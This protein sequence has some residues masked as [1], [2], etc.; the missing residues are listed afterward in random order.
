MQPNERQ[1]RKYN[2]PF[3]VRKYL[4]S[5]FVIFTFAAYALH[6]H[7]DSSE[8]VA[9]MITPT[10][11]VSIATEVS[12]ATDIP[13]PSATP[14]IVVPPT[15]LALVPT[16]TPQ[17]AALPQATATKI[18]A[19]T[20]PATATKV[21]ATATVVQAAQ[22]S[23]QYKDG[24]YTGSSANAYFGQ[25]QVKAVVQNGQLTDVQFVNYPQDRRTS[26]RINTA[27]I[28]KLKQE[29][30]TAQSAKVNIISGAT[31]TSEAFVQSLQTALNQAK[32]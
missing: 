1:T 20:V 12:R 21:P 22:S 9:A 29:A 4:V 14:L 17:V 32:A 23:G 5:A 8:A 13:L 10:Q 31:L 2:F 28:P 11:I 3:I 25:V 6:E 15:L 16:A 24:T 18:P 19:T 27:A 26:L 30:I 7:S